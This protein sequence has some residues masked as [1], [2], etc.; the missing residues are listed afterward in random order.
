MSL[1]V[2]SLVEEEGADMNGANRDGAQQEGGVA[3]LD[4]LDLNYATLCLMIAVSMVHM[5][6]WSNTGEGTKKWR[7]IF[8]ITEGKISLSWVAESLCNIYDIKNKV[9]KKIY[10]KM[11]KKGQQKS[12]TKLCD[13]VIV[14]EG[15][16]TKVIKMFKNRGSFAKPEKAYISSSLDTVFR[17]SQS[18]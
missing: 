2:T 13:R 15:V 11:L 6:K 16:K 12:S 1:R 10:S 4:Y 3:D 9:R 18:G 17:W 7:K 14:K 8:L 5:L